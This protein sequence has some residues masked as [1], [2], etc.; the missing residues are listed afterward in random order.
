MYII[1]FNSSFSGHLSDGPLHVS[2]LLTFMPLTHLCLCLLLPVHTCLP[3][4][5]QLAH[6]PENCG[7]MHGYLMMGSGRLPEGRSEGRSLRM[8]AGEPLEGRSVSNDEVSMSHGHSGQDLDYLA[9][10]PI[11]AWST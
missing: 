6:M 9:H 5:A 8:D 1:Q 4:T 2:L 3:V 7:G 10:W 11:L